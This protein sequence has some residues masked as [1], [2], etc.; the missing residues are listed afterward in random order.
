MN[1]GLC[2]HVGKESVTTILVGPVKVGKI[3]ENY[4]FLL[5]SK[6]VE[7]V[8]KL[9]VLQGLDIVLLDCIQVYFDLVLENVNLL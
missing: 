2:V 6:Q 1:Y 4:H 5:F 3:T 8:I 9:Q 7:K